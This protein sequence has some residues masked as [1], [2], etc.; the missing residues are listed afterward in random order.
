MKS[1][2]H[3]GMCEFYDNALSGVIGSC[4]RFAPVALVDGECNL[5]TVFP[6]VHPMTDWCG[7]Y[8]QRSK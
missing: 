3:C 7:E 8:E 1:D 2:Y 4:H 6:T 5:I